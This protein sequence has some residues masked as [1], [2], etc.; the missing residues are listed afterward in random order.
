VATHDLQVTLGA[1]DL[2]GTGSGGIPGPQRGGGGDLRR[3]PT[4]QAA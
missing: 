2:V 3:S 4:D 1:R